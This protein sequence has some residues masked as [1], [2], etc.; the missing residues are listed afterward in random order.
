MTSKGNGKGKCIGYNNRSTK[1]VM[2]DAGKRRA[3][4]AK[5]T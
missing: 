1:Q 4:Q 5:W 3:A 2:R